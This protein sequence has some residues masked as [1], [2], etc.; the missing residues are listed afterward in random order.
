MKKGIKFNLPLKSGDAVISPTE[1]P[2]FS[3]FGF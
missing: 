3:Q 1:L 2:F